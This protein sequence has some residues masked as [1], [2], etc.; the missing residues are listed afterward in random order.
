MII[1]TLHKTR[2]FSIMANEC[3]RRADL[4]ARAKGLWAY[5]MTL[6]DDW[7]VHKEEVF[8]HFTE[9]RD[10]MQKAWTELVKAGYVIVDPARGQS[11]KLAGWDVTVTEYA[12]Q[13]T[14]VLENRTTVS[15][16]DGKSAT[17]KDLLLPKTEELLKTS[18]TRA[19]AKNAEVDPLV[20]RL[21]SALSAKLPMTS[22]TDLD[23]Q[24]NALRHM[25]LM[26]RETQP[27][28]PLETPGQFADLA[29]ET[30]EKLR[31]SGK[32]EWWN[33]APFD[34]VSV[35][36]RWMEVVQA[37]AQAWDRKHEELDEFTRDALL[38]RAR[39]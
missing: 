5:L 23:R 29:V 32:A 13:A 22:W 28:T 33:K 10:A 2:D 12:N 36:R 27:Q 38:Q 24:M 3:L 16:N 31:R 8:S 34:P 7:T 39:R 37:M 19:I 26:I 35:E 14:D 11:G 18:T 6:P 4:S 30:Y 25:S 1:R 17:T 20:T 9:G 15:P 21:K